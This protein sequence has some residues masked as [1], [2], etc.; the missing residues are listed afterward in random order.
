MSNETKAKNSGKA[1]I[2][3]GLRKTPIIQL[4]CEKNGIGRTT[5]Y[6][7]K[8]EDKKFSEQVDKAFLEGRLF[9][10]DIAESQLISGIKDKS[11]QAI[12]FWLRNNHPVYA[13]KLEL[14]GKIEHTHELTKEQKQIVKQA[15]KLASLDKNI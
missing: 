6:R 4:V 15:V 12:F 13:D 11:M 2:I 7:W 9:I 14:K 1:L 8:K 5:F 10:N 3:E